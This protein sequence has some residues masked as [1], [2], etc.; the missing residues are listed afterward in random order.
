MPQ[1][2]TAE[3]CFHAGKSARFS[4]STPPTAWFDCLLCMRARSTVA[5]A[6]QTGRS[7]VHNHPEPGEC[8]FKC[9]RYGGHLD[10]D[11]QT[12]FADVMVKRG[13]G[14][15]VGDPMSVFNTAPQTSDIAIR[16]PMHLGEKTPPLCI[17]PAGVAR[18]SFR[19]QDE[20]LFK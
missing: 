2:T 1:M 11:G 17:A 15:V 10:G 14:S 6:V 12:A 5:Q 13:K 4:A 9:V 20:S 8:R 3:V 7:G 18:L 19:F 16:L